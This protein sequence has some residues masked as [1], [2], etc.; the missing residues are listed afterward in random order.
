MPSSR[1][2]FPTQGSNPGLPNFRRSSLALLWGIFLTQE[3]NQ[4]FLHC[5]RVLY[6]LSYQERPTYTYSH[7]FF[8]FFFCI[9]YYRVLR[10]VLCAMQHIFIS[11][12]FYIWKCACQSQFPSFPLPGS[13]LSLL[14]TMFVFSICVPISVL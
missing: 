13:L 1:G 12:L 11:S 3:L 9:G 5:R 8:Q 2:I 10:R 4:G 6:Q 14:V 7:S